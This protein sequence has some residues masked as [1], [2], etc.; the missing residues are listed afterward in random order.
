VQPGGH[1]KIPAA[2][3]IE[4]CGWKGKTRGAIGVH[5]QHALVLVNYGAGTGQ[6]ILRLAQDI[7]QS[8]YQQLNI[9]LVPEVQVIS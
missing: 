5:Q 4:Q 1:V 2:W 7:Q 3:L 6:D 8:V 9:E